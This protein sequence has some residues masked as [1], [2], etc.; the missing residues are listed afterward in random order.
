MP[1]RLLIGYLSFILLV[2]TPVCN[3]LEG[4]NEIVSQ[5]EFSSSLIDH[6]YTTSTSTTGTEA[7]FMTMGL[8]WIDKY[9]FMDY[10]IFYDID[11]ATGDKDPN[12]FAIIRYGLIIIGL[13]LMV[14]VFFYT[15]A[16]S[17]SV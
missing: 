7:N 4:T 14:V 10:S 6:S 17:I 3:M 12:D 1:I 8:D 9:V 5:S 16:S 2:V 11:P 13:A 15:R